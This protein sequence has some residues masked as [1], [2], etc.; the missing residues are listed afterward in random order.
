MRMM[1]RAKTVPESKLSFREHCTNEKTPVFMRILSK[2]KTV[3]GS[4][5]SFREHCTDEGPLSL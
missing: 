1:S 3:S 2:E 5:L 4:I